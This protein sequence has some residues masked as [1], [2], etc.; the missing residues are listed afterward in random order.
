MAPRLHPGLIVAVACSA[1]MLASP[2]WATTAVQYVVGF[3]AGPPVQTGDTFHG[4]TVTGT[5]LAIKFATVQTTDAPAFL[6][7][8]ATDPRVRYVDEDKRT[9]AFNDT[10]GG[11]PPAPEGGCGGYTP[12][13]PLF[14]T[15]YG[16]VQ[17]RADCGWTT[18]L[19]STAAKVCVVD[20]GISHDH[21]DVTGARLLGEYNFVAD[22][23]D[24]TDDHGHGTAVTSVAAATIN[25]GFGMAGIGN[26]GMYVAKAVAADGTIQPS[27]VA[28][29]ITWCADTAGANTV[30]VLSLG[31]YEFHQ[32]VKDALVYS[33][34]EKGQLIVAAAGNDGKIPGSTFPASE[35]EVIGVSCTMV[36]ELR[37][38]TSNGGYQQLAAPG[39]LIL[40][41]ALGF[42]G[43]TVASGTSF[44]APHVAGAAAL[45][46][47]HEPSHTN[48]A[49]WDRLTRTAQD[50]GT[51]GWDNYFGY[52]EVDVDC[53]FA[54]RS[55]CDAT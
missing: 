24:A 13:D 31:W 48:T 40:V 36:L 1:A 21:A 44:S 4:G 27:W 8:V 18:T 37:C 47:S 22:N 33:F 50:L 38:P 41:A 10:L 49:L 30:V 11:T 46:W 39:E 19:G 9:P 42:Q 53:L 20:S 43:F 12:D 7:S 26:V 25:N 17:I 51:D 14:V 15:Q 6:D 5:N 34:S 3:H 54:N 52:G 16:P 28:N 55:P 29:G 2:A 35:P 23:G 32:V 45:F